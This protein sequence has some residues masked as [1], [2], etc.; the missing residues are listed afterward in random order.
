MGQSGG[1][2]RDSVGNNIKPNVRDH[3]LSVWYNMGD[4]IQNSVSD[5]VFDHVSANMKLQLGYS[6]AECVR[7]SLRDQGQAK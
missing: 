7:D 5:L 1:N 3:V 6:V 2:V 4:N